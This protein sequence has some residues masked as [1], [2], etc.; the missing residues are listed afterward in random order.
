MDP[1]DAG[2]LIF[3]ETYLIQVQKIKAAYISLFGIESVAAL[4]DSIVFKHLSQNIP[5][6]VAS[7]AGKT[8]DATLGK[9]QFFD[10][11]KREIIAKSGLAKVAHLLRSKTGVDSLDLFIPD[12][13][14]FCFDDLE[15][16]SPNIDIK[17]IM[18]F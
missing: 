4:R 12:G 8:W 11:K 3:G 2:K 13:A 17:D 14:V 1:G 6:K 18:E 15:R 16:H 9:I 7:K 10:S 5:E